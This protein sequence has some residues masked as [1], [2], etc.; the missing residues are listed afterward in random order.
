MEE[1][2]KKARELDPGLSL[3]S[4][5]PQFFKRAEEKIMKSITIAITTTRRFLFNSFLNFFESLRGI[6]SFNHFG[7]FNF[8]Y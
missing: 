1:K 6:S 5:L 8:V 4:S 7:E 3:K 2:K